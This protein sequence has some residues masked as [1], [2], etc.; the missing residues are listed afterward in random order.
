ML[1]TLWL[2]SSSSFTVLTF[3][4]FYGVDGGVRAEAAFFAVV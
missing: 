3:F 4:F 1:P 2:V